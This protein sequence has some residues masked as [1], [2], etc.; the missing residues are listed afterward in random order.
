MRPA[1]EAILPLNE[2]AEDEP[3]RRRDDSRPFQTSLPGE[4]ETLR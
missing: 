1:D 4:R 2:P 3:A